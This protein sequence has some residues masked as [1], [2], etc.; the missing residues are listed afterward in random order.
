MGTALRASVFVLGGVH[1]RVHLRK[2]LRL[3]GACFTTRCLAV[4]KSFFHRR[5]ACAMAAQRPISDAARRTNVPYAGANPIDPAAWS[6]NLACPGVRLRLPRHAPVSKKSN[7]CHGYHPLSTHTPCL[8][9]NG[10]SNLM[11]SST[12]PLFLQP[13]RLF[14]LDPQTVID[15]LRRCPFSEPISTDTSDHI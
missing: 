10:L 6:K 2:L 13:L 4:F 11:P 3:L 1:R 9:A 12:S 15:Y 5:W 7:E 8:T 14:P